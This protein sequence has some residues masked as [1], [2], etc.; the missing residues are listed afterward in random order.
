MWSLISEY[1]EDWNIVNAEKYYDKE[2][3]I[4][5]KRNISIDFDFHQ[6]TSFPKFPPEHA[7]TL[8]T[9]LRRDI[10]APIPL[11]D[12]CSIFEHSTEK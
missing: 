4:L 8:G 2:L 5:Y 1:D 7:F 11:I 6:Q 10:S 3:M 12:R 9:C